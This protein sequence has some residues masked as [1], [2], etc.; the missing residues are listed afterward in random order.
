MKELAIVWQRLVSEEGKTCDRCGATQIELERAVKV[1]QEVLRPLDIDPVLENRKIDDATFRADPSLSNRIA[2][3]GKPMEEWL[4]ANVG[5]SPCCSV[6]GDAECRTVQI[7]RTTFETIP[8][9]LV[10]RAGLIAAAH[11]LE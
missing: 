10:V 5:S 6:C 9:R 3:D 4:N 7:G 11:L 2:I 8:E 1:L